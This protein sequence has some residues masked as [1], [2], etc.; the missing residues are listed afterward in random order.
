MWFQL[1]MDTLDISCHYCYKTNIFSSDDPSCNQ[2]TT[3][4]RKDHSDK[5]GPCTAELWT[6]SRNIFMTEV[7]EYLLCQALRIIASFISWILVWSVTILDLLLFC[8]KEWEK[9][10]NAFDINSHTFKT[11]SKS[12]FVSGKQTQ[13]TMQWTTQDFCCPSTTLKSGINILTKPSFSTCSYAL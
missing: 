9:N 13:R 12:C 1:N 10:Y 7:Y 6:Q 3:F 11:Y 5:T 4:Y 8:N 2:I